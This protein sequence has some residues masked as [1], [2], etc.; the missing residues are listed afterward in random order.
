MVTRVTKS[1]EQKWTG[2]PDT[3]CRDRRK[4][5]GCWATCRREQATSDWMSVQ[6]T[7]QLPR[8]CCLLQMGQK[9]GSKYVGAMKDSLA[10]VRAYLSFII[11]VCCPLYCSCA[12]PETSCL[13]NLLVAGQ[14]RTCF[15]VLSG[16][17]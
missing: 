1:Q 14:D 8:G 15:A 16:S 13:N 4:G 7:L 2:Q 3:I 5:E 17:C 11:N 6:A 10:F 9:H 12:T